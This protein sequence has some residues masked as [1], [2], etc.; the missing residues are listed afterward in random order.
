MHVPLAEWWI[1]AEETRSFLQEEREGGPWSENFRIFKRRRRLRLCA[2]LDR[3]RCFAAGARNNPAVPVN[4]K[5]VKGF[6]HPRHA[7]PHPRLRTGD[8]CRR[9]TEILA[10]VDAHAHA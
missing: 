5:G 4:V 3:R 9:V 6:A 1:G 2:L 7:E 10:A 8:Q